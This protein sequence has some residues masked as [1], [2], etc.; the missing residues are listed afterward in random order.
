MKNKTKSRCDCRTRIMLILSS[1]LIVFLITLTVFT[2]VST[3][4][5]IREG[6]NIG[7]G[8]VEER[9]I[10]VSG[11]GEIYAVP[12]LALLTFSVKT[13]AG[14]VAHAM[15]ENTEEMNAVVALMKALGI[16]ERDLKTVSFNIHPRYEWRKE[17]E[18]D[19]RFLQPEGRRTLVAYEVRQSLQVKV[20]E[21]EKIGD[22]IQGA[23]GAGANQVGSL[24]FTID[25]EDELRKQARKEAIQ[26]AKEKAKELAVQLN[27]ELLRVID[28]SEHRGAPRLSRH[29]LAPMVAEA[30]EVGV[31][32]IEV[33]ENKIEVVVAITFEID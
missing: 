9:T 30:E 32:R 7:Q 18:V 19:A 13:E 23:T 5:K 3:Q 21:I 22:I 29:I 20:R 26:E 11:T 27:V 31:P 25:N 14:T 6:K 33:G 12:D 1:V 24:H 16:G 2:I 28:F 8:L 4:N 10:T 15:A 17:P